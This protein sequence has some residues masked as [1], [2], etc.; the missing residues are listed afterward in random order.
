MDFIDKTEEQPIYFLPCTKKDY[1]NCI[2]DCLL[3][4]Y[5]EKIHTYIDFNDITDIRVEIT[6]SRDK[7]DDMDEALYIAKIYFVI[8]GKIY[9]LIDSNYP[10]SKGIYYR[11]LYR[12]IMKLILDGFDKIYNERLYGLKYE[13]LMDEFFNSQTVLEVYKMYAKTTGDNNSE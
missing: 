12:K 11:K 8:R 3:Y 6:K 10:I 7:Y 5:R 9:K 4:C 1:E 2:K 13:K